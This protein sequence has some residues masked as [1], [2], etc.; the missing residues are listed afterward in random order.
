MERLPGIARDRSGP[1]GRDVAYGRSTVVAMIL[2]FG[3]RVR[4]TNVG[5]GE[6][7]CPHCGADRHYVM[8]ALRR[9]FTFFFIPIFPS[10]KELGRQVVCSTC[11]TAFREDV[12]NAPTSSALSDHIRNAMR[13]ASVAM[14]RAGGE[15]SAARAAASDAIRA[16]GFTDYDDATSRSDLASADVANLAGYLAPLASG[17]GE[18]R[19]PGR[20]DRPGRRHAYPRRDGAPRLNR[21]DARAESGPRARHCRHRGTGCTVDGFARRVRPPGFIELAASHSRRDRTVGSQR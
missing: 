2:I 20:D 3:F 18:L 12:L 15:T 8:R 14:L 19:Q 5:E 6:F 16:T 11:N 7:F 4:G 21:Y 1:G 17:Q 10:G 9:W 13:V